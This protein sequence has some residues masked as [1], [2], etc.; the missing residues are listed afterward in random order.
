MCVYTYVFICIYMCVFMS[1][2]Y[3]GIYSQ[4]YVKQ[5]PGI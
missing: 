2:G 5:A 4:T 3:T 1:R